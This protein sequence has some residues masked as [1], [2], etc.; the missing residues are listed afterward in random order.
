MNTV[1]AVIDDHDD[2]TVAAAA[3][4]R[5]A[6]IT[7][8][9][10]PNIAWHAIDWT[11]VDVAVVDLLMPDPDGFTILAEL[12]RHHPNVARVAWSAWIGIGMDEGVTARA[13]H[14]AHRVVA[15]EALVE[16]PDVIHEL[17][18]HR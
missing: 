5:L 11:H 4:L 1:A 18:G 10:V 15:K 14:L 7:V 2:M 9:E 13:E 12:E 8:I 6:G 16:L 17:V 3:I